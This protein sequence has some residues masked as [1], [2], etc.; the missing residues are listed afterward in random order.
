MQRVNGRAAA[1]TPI[2]S[3][4]PHV[5]H[6][7][8]AGLEDRYLG[9]ASIADRFDLIAGTS[10]GG[11][12]ALG[13]GVMGVAS[14]GSFRPDSPYTVSGAKLSLGG[15]LFWRPGLLPASCSTSAAD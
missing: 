7:R 2:C 5:H 9:G 11:I 8:H 10:T 6:L 1:V 4:F 15:L 14:E 13:L 12:L 3:R